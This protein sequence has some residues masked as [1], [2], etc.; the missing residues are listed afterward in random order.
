MKFIQSIIKSNF[1]QTFSLVQVTGLNNSYTSI[2]YI[3]LIWFAYG[4]PLLNLMRISPDLGHFQD[5]FTL[6]IYI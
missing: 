3:Y 2:I 1:I 5:L 6:T 4:C